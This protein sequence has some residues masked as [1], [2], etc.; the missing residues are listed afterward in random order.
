MRCD[1]VGAL[2]LDRRDPLHPRAEPR[3]RRQVADGAQA[4]EQQRDRAGLVVGQRLAP[5]VE[6]AEEGAGVAVAQP[7]LPGGAAIDDRPQRLGNRMRRGPGQAHELAAVRRQARHHLAGIGNAERRLVGEQAVQQQ[8]A[9]EH[10]ALGGAAL[11]PQHRGVERHRPVV[12]AAV[13][14]IERALVRDRERHDSDLAALVDEQGMELRVEM[15]DTGVV[16]EGQGAQH[17]L[18]PERGL[19]GGRLGM[20]GQPFV[21][22]DAGAAIDDDIRPLLVD[23]AGEHPGE[24]GMVEPGRAAHRREPGGDGCR[25]RGRDPGQAEH[26][27]GA[28]PGVVGQP[29]HRRL[30]LAEQAAQ[31]IAAERARRCRRD[32]GGGVGSS[33]RHREETKQPRLEPPRGVAQRP[34]SAGFVRYL[35]LGTAVTSTR[36]RRRRS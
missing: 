34:I 4:V 1:L 11:R 33:D 19:V 36:R 31:P 17:L 2:A 28:G 7:D 22:R 25:A 16:G 5:A 26:H 3:Q 9:G 30:A 10:V 13:R 20:L 12:V 23:V 8:A 6:G 27:L 15:G 14:R 24:A 18:H 35:S 32:G 21:E 29:G